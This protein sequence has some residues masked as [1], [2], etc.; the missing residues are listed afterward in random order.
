MAFQAN[1]NKQQSCS[2]LKALDI[3]PYT[4]SWHFHN[5]MENVWCRRRPHT[6]PLMCEPS[7]QRSGNEGRYLIMNG[8]ERRA[9]LLTV[10]PHTSTPLSRKLKWKFGPW[11]ESRVPLTCA[12]WFMAGDYITTK[13]PGPFGPFSAPTLVSRTSLQILFTDY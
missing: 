4:L 8:R 13:L 6:C 12:V 3:S 9:W 10:S 5:L 1:R 7:S 11:T 2:I